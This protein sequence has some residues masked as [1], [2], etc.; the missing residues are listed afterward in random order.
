MDL[1]MRIIRDPVVEEKYPNVAVDSTE[2]SL[3]SLL[4]RTVGGILP[5]LSPGGDLSR[6]ANLLLNERPVRIA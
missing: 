5:F 1:E 2:K 4:E 3:K 6:L